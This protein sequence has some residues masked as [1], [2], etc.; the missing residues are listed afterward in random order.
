MLSFSISYP[1]LIKNF[2]LLYFGGP[3]SKRGGGGGIVG[4]KE[5]QRQGEERLTLRKTLSMDTIYLLLLQ[6]VVT[7]NA[8]LEYA[9]LFW[10]G[11]GWECEETKLI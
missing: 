9:F 3:H 5:A 4:G 1:D 7:C 8:I 11:V 10:V 2:P 6:K